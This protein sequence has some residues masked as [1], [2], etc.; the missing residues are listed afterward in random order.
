MEFSFFE[1]NNIL[2][3]IKN[4][5]NVK[6]DVLNFKN[7]SID[8]RTILSNELFV[9]IKGKDFDGHSFLKEIIQKGVKAVVIQE[10]MKKLLPSDLPYWYVPDTI[11]AFQ[12][13]ALFKRRKLNIPV[14]GITGSVGKTTTKEMIGEVLK[15]LGKIKFS[16]ANFNNEIGVALT[17]L[18]TNLKDQVLLLEMGMRGLGQIENLSKFSEPNIA[19]ITNIGSAHIGLLGS[20]EN[21]TYA[22]CEITK[23]LNPNGVVIIPAN[24]IFLEKTL[25]KNWNG[26][27]LK[28]ELLDINQINNNINTNNLRG[29]YNRLSDSIL[30]EDKIFDISFK[31]FHNASNFLFAYAVA[32]EFNINFKNYNKFNFVSLDG[33]NKIL[34]S[35]KTTIY[36]ETYNASPESVKACIE[37]LLVTP[38]N[39]FIIF[40][41]MQELGKKSKQFH[42]DIFDFINRTDVKKCIFICN[43]NDEKYYSLYLNKN[44]KFLFLNDIKN[45]GKIINK[46]TREGDCILIKGSRVWELEKIIKLID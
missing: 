1:V 4:L 30:I 8:S 42:K 25:R 3:N 45:A 15:R 14:V 38:N 28:V 7:I 40:G 43:A 29:F 44:N 33:R 21:I 36:D 2:G 41:S 22:K 35:K 16:H 13:L 11:E 39:H 12:K 34:K 24:D 37:N 27:I 46:F 31:G 10:G 17:I 5:K 20:K 32:K 26:R 19:I 6:K 9:A 23:H 18:D